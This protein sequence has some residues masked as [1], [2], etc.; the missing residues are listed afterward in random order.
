[1]RILT[2]DIGEFCENKL[3]WGN[4]EMVKEKTNK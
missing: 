1:M 4:E 2:S 3:D